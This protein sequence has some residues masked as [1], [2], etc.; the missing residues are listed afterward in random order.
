MEVR[1]S[2]LRSTA[3]A[4]AARWKSWTSIFRLRV[5]LLTLLVAAIALRDVLLFVV[6]IL[7]FALV[8]ATGL[9]TKRRRAP[10]PGV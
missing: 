9:T 1:T 3:R 6:S 4:M 10:S 7:L 5:V 8:E 2:R